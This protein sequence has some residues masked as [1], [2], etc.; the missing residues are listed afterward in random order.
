MDW[1]RLL[2][3]PGI[4]PQNNHGKKANFEPTHLQWKIGIGS[5]WPHLETFLNLADSVIFSLPLGKEV[6]IDWFCAL[7]TQVEIPIALVK[8]CRQRPFLKLPVGHEAPGVFWAWSFLPGEMLVLVN[9]CGSGKTLELFVD[10]KESV[11]YLKMR[12]QVNT[13]QPDIGCLL[14]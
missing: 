13:Y 11:A 5:L 2:P 10:P 9:V 3:F 6:L 4:T 12:I 8:F 14:C 7:N 1:M